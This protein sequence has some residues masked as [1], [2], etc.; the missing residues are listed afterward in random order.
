MEKAKLI[1][2][3][4]EIAYDAWSSAANSYRMYPENKHT[5]SNHWELNNNQYEEYV[6]ILTSLTAPVDGKVKTYQEIE[7]WVDDNES[8][9]GSWDSYLRFAKWIQGTEIFKTPDAG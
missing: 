1:E 3:I 5:F 2:I 6:A 4:K 9:L 7:Q 8:D